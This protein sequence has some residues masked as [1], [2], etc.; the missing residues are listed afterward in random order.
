MPADEKAKDVPKI[1]GGSGEAI[2]CSGDSE[3]AVAGVSD[4][5]VLS[6]GVA[7]GSW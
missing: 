1:L 7:A 5:G 4:T 6:D 3:D 2:G